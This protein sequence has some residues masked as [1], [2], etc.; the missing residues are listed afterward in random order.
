[1]MVQCALL[2]LLFAFDFSTFF[3]I[4]STINHNQWFSNC[5]SLMD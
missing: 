5:N 3:I 4:N 2:V 1:M